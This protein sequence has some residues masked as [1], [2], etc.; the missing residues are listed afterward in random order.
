MEPL[1]LFAAKLGCQALQIQRQHQKSH[2]P[3][4]GRYKSKSKTTDGPRSA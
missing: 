1:L 2:P 3:K 4:N